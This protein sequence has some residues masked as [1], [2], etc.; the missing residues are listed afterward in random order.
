[1]TLKGQIISECPYEIIISPIRPTKKIKNRIQ[2]FDKSYNVSNFVRFIQL[3]ESDN[4]KYLL[5]VV[6]LFFL[7]S[8][9]Q[10]FT[11]IVLSVYKLNKLGK[12][13]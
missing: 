4:Q 1:M 3:N 7:R 13:G 9:A 11:L 5:F 12:F 10:F 6:R 8:I 2:R